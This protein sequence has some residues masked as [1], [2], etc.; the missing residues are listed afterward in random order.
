ME[1]A[2]S[3][4]SPMQSFRG[5]VEVGAAGVL[6]DEA[7]PPRLPPWS[8]PATWR[9]VTAALDHH[10]GLPHFRR[11]NMIRQKAGA[12][13]HLMARLDRPMDALSRVTCPECGDPCC[14]RATLWYD[15][16]DL[17]VM[18]STC[19]PWPPGQPMAAVGAQ[20]RYLG[21]NG[22]R[23]PR[24]RRPWICTWYLCPRQTAHLEAV[25]PAQRETI[26]RLITGVKQLRRGL[27][28]AF[29]DVAMGGLDRCR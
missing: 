8:R 24:I 2:G 10:L 25:W 14:R 21:P 11:Q 9:A 26:N 6:I 13:S 16:V 1:K 5:G 27:Q 20:C 29:I 3:W 22:C 18:G 12:I 23:L 4:R 15:F 28:G 19:Q 7:W 17:L